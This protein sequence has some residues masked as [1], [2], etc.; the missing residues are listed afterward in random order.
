MWLAFSHMMNPEFVEVRGA[1]IR[2]RSY[3]PDRFEEWHRK[4]GGDV[5]R[6]ESVLNRFVPGYEIECGDS[7]EDEAALGDVAR[8]VAY[9]WEAALARA[10]PER[11][12][13]VRVVETDDGPTVVFHQVPA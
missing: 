9:S 1:V 6:I 13:E 2:R 3:H 11:R 10:F 12:F 7:A 4:L 5:R 8:A